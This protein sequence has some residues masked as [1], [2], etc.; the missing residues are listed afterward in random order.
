MKTKKPTIEDYIYWIKKTEDMSYSDPKS[1][2]KYN[3]AVE[4][5]SEYWRDRNADWCD[6]EYHQFVALTRH[7]DPLV[8][9][10]VVVAIIVKVKL[11]DSTLNEFLSILDSAVLKLN[12][13]RRLDF[14]MWMSCWKKGMIKTQN[15]YNGF[16]FSISG[17]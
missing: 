5:A 4:K 14:K 16:V 3:I 12:R 13:D 15:P 6:D 9:A 1:V 17:V 7:E 10:S 11:K 8:R 2:R